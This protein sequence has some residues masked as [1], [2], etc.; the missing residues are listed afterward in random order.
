[1]EWVA[2]CA[3]IFMFFMVSDLRRVCTLTDTHRSA[4]MK[5]VDQDT[6]SDNDP[7][8][9][10]SEA[11]KQKVAPLLSPSRSLPLCACACVRACLCVSVCDFPYG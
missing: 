7:L 2:L 10:K 3:R 9:I 6:G 11:E 8:Q 4:S 1:M 5:Y